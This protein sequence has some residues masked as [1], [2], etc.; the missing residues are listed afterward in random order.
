[1]RDW[2][3]SL[4]RDSTQNPVRLHKS[5]PSTR[6][7]TSRASCLKLA[8]PPCT[9]CG[10]STEYDD[11]AKSWPPLAALIALVVACQANSKPDEIA[12]GTARDPAASASQP[13]Q[14]SDHPPPTQQQLPAPQQSNSGEPA[15]TNVLDASKP[16]LPPAA[17]APAEP[18]SSAMSPTAAAPASAPAPSETSATPE[19]PAPDSGVVLDAGRDS[20]LDAGR[21]PAAFVPECETAADCVLFGGCCECSAQAV[22]S[23]RIE[24]PAECDQARCARD[25]ITAQDLVCNHG[26]CILNRSCTADTVGCDATPPECAAN[27]RATQRHD[28][29]GPCIARDDCFAF[30]DCSDC[31]D[32]EVCVQTQGFTITTECV[33]QLS[34]CTPGHYVECLNLPGCT[35]DD[36]GV[37]ECVCGG[38]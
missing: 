25:G 6:E 4:G 12:S 30:A 38:C 24:C 28:C 2:P 23:D 9:V 10:V 20:V 29:W 32:G 5:T 31:T 35:E 34:S 27:E 22:G 19:S 1:M 11:W 15:A 3:A 7:T 33:P 13:S 18:P 16:V 14:A 36:A 17:S 37:L 26:R 8:T 21:S